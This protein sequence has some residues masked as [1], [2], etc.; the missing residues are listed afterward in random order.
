MATQLVQSVPDLEQYGNVVPDGYL[1]YKKMV[2]AAEDLR[3]PQ[4]YLK[5]YDIY[6]TDAPVTDE[7]RAECR[8]FVAEEAARWIRS[9]AQPADLS[10]GRAH[11]QINK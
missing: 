10:P 3:L 11:I 7:Q 1:Y 2:T 4:A 5:W 8:A 9:T 6:P